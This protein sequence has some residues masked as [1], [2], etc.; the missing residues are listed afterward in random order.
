MLYPSLTLSVRGRAAWGIPDAMAVVVN[1]LAYCRMAVVKLDKQASR[2]V[3]E[4]RDDKPLYMTSNII[5]MVILVG[6]LS[7]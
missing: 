3:V 2:S 6:D 4:H 7:T 1:V 5:M